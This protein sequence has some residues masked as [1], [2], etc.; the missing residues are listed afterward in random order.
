MEI[1]NIDKVT[2]P[3]I[4]DAR[5]IKLKETSQQ[6]EASFLTFVFKAMEK[7]VPKSEL[8]EGSSNNLSTML[9]STTMADAVSQQGGMG[10]ADQIYH[11]LLQSNELPNL[12]NLTKDNVVGALEAIKTMG[13]GT[14]EK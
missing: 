11:S 10:L 6:M 7:T 8:N 3:K 13:I 9:F 12:D 4:D 2:L 5:N 1:G 14:S